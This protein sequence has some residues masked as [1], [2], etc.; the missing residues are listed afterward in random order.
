MWAT[1]QSMQSAWLFRSIRVGGWATDTRTSE[2]KVHRG[3]GMRHTS[4]LFI[5]VFLQ[6][7]K[8]YAHDQANQLWPS[9]TDLLTVLVSL[10]DSIFSCNGNPANMPCWKTTPFLTGRVEIVYRDHV[11]I[12]HIL[13]WS[14]ADTATLGQRMRGWCLHG[15][16]H[17]SK[18]SV[19]LT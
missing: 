15:I 13:S 14:G 6:R 4:S 9:V 19:V 5:L 18:C 17:L 3:V 16:A 7:C 1:R 2:M 11:A 12:A 8:P 10:V